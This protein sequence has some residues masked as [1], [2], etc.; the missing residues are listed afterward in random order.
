MQILKSRAKK[1]HLPT[2]KRTEYTSTCNC[3]IKKYK[4]ITIL[5]T[6]CDLTFVTLRNLMAFIIES[7]N[8]RYFHYKLFLGYTFTQPC[9]DVLV[10]I[11]Y[12]K[13]AYFIKKNDHYL[14]MI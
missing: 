11:K 8:D 10:I 3:F 7:L 9:D 2:F 13:N 6:T 14:I 12:D 5:S 4:I 1:S